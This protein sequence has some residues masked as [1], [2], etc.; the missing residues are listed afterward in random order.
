MSRFS[1]GQWIE[2][3]AHINAVGSSVAAARE[4]DTRA[5]AQ[6]SL[7]IDRRESTQSEAGDFLIPKQEGAIDDDHIRGEIGEILLGEIEGRRSPEEI[8]LFKSLGLAVEDL[9]AAHYI[10]GRAREEGLGTAVEIGEL[11]DAAR[12]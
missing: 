2:P 5:V 8:T 6:A 7:F 4:L 9:Q 12:A 10:V 3:G 1:S 11:P